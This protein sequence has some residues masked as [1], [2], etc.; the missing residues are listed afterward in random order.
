MKLTPPERLILLTLFEIREKLDG[1]EN[2][3]F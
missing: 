3:T 1:E 2:D